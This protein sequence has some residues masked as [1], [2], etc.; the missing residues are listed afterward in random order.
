MP[1]AQV[2]IIESPF[3][4]GAQGLY[5]GLVAWLAQVGELTIVDVD[6]W[7][8]NSATYTGVQRLRVLYYQGVATDST[9]IAGF[10]RSG[11]WEQVATGASAANQFNALMQGGSPFL[12]K[13]TLDITAKGRRNASAETFITLGINTQ[14]SPLVGS[15]TTVWIGQPSAPIAAGAT[16][17][18]D[19]IDARGVTVGTA[20]VRNVGDIWVANQ[21]TYVVWDQASGELIAAPTCCSASLTPLVPPSLTTTTPFSA[22]AYIPQTAPVGG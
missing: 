16:G 13:F 4:T 1:A 7:R 9:W 19:L 14:A 12:L 8:E 2:A 18:V 10:W 6:V 15:P 11:S 5:D 22:P 17:T 3:S 20:T 21:R